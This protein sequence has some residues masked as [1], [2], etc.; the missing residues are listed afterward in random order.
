MQGGKAWHPKITQFQSGFTKEEPDLPRV[1][2]QFHDKAENRWWNPG[3]LSFLWVHHIITPLITY[4]PSSF[5][6]LRQEGP[7]SSLD[8]LQVILTSQRLLPSH[9]VFLFP[10][11]CTSQRNRPYAPNCRVPFCLTEQSF[12]HFSVWLHASK[13]KIPFICL[14]Q[15]KSIMAQFSLLKY[16]QAIF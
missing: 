4:L 8:I 10:F 14:V 13:N 12:Y 7:N 15:G 5:L 11:Q 3:S 6:Y 1:T 2:Q 9:G 16:S